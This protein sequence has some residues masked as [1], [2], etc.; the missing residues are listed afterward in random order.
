MNRN[1]ESHFAELPSVDVPRSIFDRS[2]TVK[3]S[4]NVGELIP[5]CLEEV[6]PGDTFRVSTSKIVRLQTMLT[7]VMDNLY[8]DVYWFFDPLINLWDHAK[9]FFGENSSSAWVPQVSY[10]VPSISSPS[11]GFATGTIADYLGLPVG[12]QWTNLASKRPSALPFRMYARIANEFFRDQN[13]SDPLNIPYGD[14]NQT[15]TNGSNYITDTVN[16]GMP[17]KVAKYHDYFTSCLPAPQ[18]GP[19]V[20]MPVVNANLAPVYARNDMTHWS[21]GDAL[22][23]YTGGIKYGYSTGGNFTEYTSGVN[24]Y[25]LYNKGIGYSTGTGEGSVYHAAIPANLYADLTS[26]IGSVNINELRLAFQ[27]QRY[28][29]RQAR[30]GSRYTEYLKSFFGTTS[31]DQVLRRPE[32]L[33]GNRIQ[34]NVHEVLNTAQ[35]QSDYLGDLGGMSV[36]TDVNDD[37]THSFTMHGYVMGVMCLRYDHSYP[38]GMDRHWFRR[39]AMDFY[40]PV[41]SSLGEM[42]VYKCQICADAT[43][44]DDDSVFGYQEAWA[45]YRFSRDICTGEMRPGVSNTLSSWHYADYYTTVPTLSDSWIREDKTMVDRTLAVTSSVSNQAF[46]DIYIKNLCTRVMPVYSIPGLI[47]HH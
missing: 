12:V 37:F 31:P 41:F 27:L 29:E 32:Y 35:T 21:A 7:P 40:N 47:D 14:S 19:A 43:N 45:E 18:K 33:G 34:I 44:M 3:T 10:Q 28:Y 15:G 4:F 1:V 39:D 42:P 38:Q 25:N 46:A 23:T 11:G 30:S 16:G 2:H 17:F 26:T 8:L 22:P 24:A 6:L 9:E 5:F 36:T 20:T 13:L